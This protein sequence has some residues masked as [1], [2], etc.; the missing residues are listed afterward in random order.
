MR[1]LNTLNKTKL[2][3]CLTLLMALPVLLI[4]VKHQTDIK[5]HASSPDKL[6]AE[7]G[8]LAGNAKN[9]TDSNASGGSF[10]A[11]G[12]NPTPTPTTTPNPTNTPTPTSTALLYPFETTLTKQNQPSMTEPNLLETKTFSDIGTKVTRVS[13]IRHHY[14]KNNPWNSDESLAL[15]GTQ[16]TG[17]ILNGNTYAVTGTG[18]SFMSGHRTWSNMDPRYIYGTQNASNQWVRLDATNGT[19]TALHTYTADELG[20]SSLTNI[21]YGKSEGNMDNNDTSVVLIAN[22]L[23]PFIANPKTGNFRCKITKTYINVYDTNMS[24][25][26]NYALVTY[27]ENGNIAIDSF[28]PQTC[29]FQRTV[30][31][32]RV[33]HWDACVSQAGEQV[34]VTSIGSSF[35]MYRLS[36]GADLGVQYSDSALRQHISCRN[37]KRPG[38]A[39][40]SA[41]NDTCDST[42]TDAKMFNRVFAIK[43]DGSQKVQVF[44]WD[45]QACPSNYDQNSMASPSRYG[46]RVWWK[47]NWDGVSSG[48]HSFVAQQ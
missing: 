26:G 16:G 10:I 1:R 14:S 4:V 41:Y 7:G 19:R 22:G 25:D 47:T 27:N 5:S 37:T 15:V 2:I 20:L 30:I 29:I 34:I 43:L 8:I 12:I 39:Y 40:I 6:E 11:L 21:D 42:A 18:Y 31:T 35:R 45:H 44:A 23:V 24:Q 13:N 3:L 32:S 28:N 38:W 9:Q 17:T 33:S 36:D 48:I 46:D